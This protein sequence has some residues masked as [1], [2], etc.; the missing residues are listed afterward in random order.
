MQ[1][2]YQPDDRLAVMM[3]EVNF[4]FSNTSGV[5]LSARVNAGRWLSGNVFTAL[6]YRHDKCDD[7]YNLPFDRDKC[8]VLT[9]NLVYTFGKYKEKK[10]KEVDTSRMGH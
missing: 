4:D 2:A 8:T 1:I 3:K 6:T 9:L 10:Q 7:F 5:Q